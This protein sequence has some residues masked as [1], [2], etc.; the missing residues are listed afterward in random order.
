M[1]L[2]LSFGRYITR[3]KNLAR[4]FGNSCQITCRWLEADGT[5]HSAT[6]VSLGLFSESPDERAVCWHLDARSAV[7]FD[8]WDL[9]VK[10]STAAKKMSGRGERRHEKN[11][12]GAASLTRVWV[13]W[14][15][16][17]RN[18]TKCTGKRAWLPKAWDVFSLLF[19][20][21]VPA[22]I[23]KETL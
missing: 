6:E 17:N 8:K 7:S 22:F 11:G 13:I 15:M 4:C 20:G 12:E 3:L 23:Y 19:F 16:S 21:A 10:V 14:M 5:G 18:C 9:C 1:S 2:A